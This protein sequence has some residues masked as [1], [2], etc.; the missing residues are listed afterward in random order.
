MMATTTTA[1]LAT[2][3]VGTWSVHDDSDDKNDGDGISHYDSLGSGDS[4]SYMRS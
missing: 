2:A 3:T 4:R 1:A